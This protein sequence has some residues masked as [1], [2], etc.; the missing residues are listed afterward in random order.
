MTSTIRSLGAK[1]LL[2]SALIPLLALPACGS[3]GTSGSTGGSQSQATIKLGS[4][5][6]LEGRIISEMYNLL[7]T[8]A[9]FNVKAVSPGENAF[10]FNGIKN[11]DIDIYPEFTSTGMDSL[12]LKPT[13]DAQKD[14]QTV[15]AGF[16]K[17]FQITWLNVSSGLNDTYAFCTSK[18]RASELGVTTLSQLT[19]KLSNLTLALQPD[20]L[21][22]LDF[23]T[24]VYGINQKSFKSIQKVDYSIGF[25]SVASKQADL[26][27][28]YSTDVT[29]AQKNF[30]VIQDDKNAFP[31][32]NPAP[33]VRDSVLKANPKIADALN[34]LAPLLTNEVSLTLQKE[35]L[36]KQNSGASV[37]QS[38][39]ATDT[40]F[41]KSKGL[42]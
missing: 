35:A 7:L 23:L 1:L 42:L 28:C 40:D 19:P 12:K 30:V 9:G 37:E 32:Y 27:F 21:Y 13:T 29:I 14:Y 5:K 6:D 2:L 4:K 15:K 34:P 25:S 11:G 20:G 24:P 33:I 38:I 31:A 18:A 22:V 16:E 26:N 10:V 39:K 36:D 41:L 17:Q 3:G 8:K